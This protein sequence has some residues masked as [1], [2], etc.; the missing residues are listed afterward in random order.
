MGKHFIDQT[1]QQYG[2]LKVLTYVG[3]KEGRTKN[4]WECLCVCGNLI[5]TTGSNLTAGHTQ[6]CGCLQIEEMKS[7]RLYN[8]S[9]AAEYQ[10]WRG[11][12]QRTT[13]CSGRNAIW[14]SD[15]ACCSEWSASFEVF[16]K[17]MGKRPGTHYSIERVNNSEGYSASNCIWATAQEQANNRSS[18]R[19]LEFQ[20]ESLTIA[21]WSRRTNIKQHTICARLDRYKWSV[22]AALTTATN[23]RRP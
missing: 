23:K 21:E 5:E 12:K 15:V 17:D 4:Y 10:I 8:K 19:L 13:A 2:L 14:Y 11:I 7:R 9:D 22:E 1:G 16:L 3:K 20:Q 6:S 18:N